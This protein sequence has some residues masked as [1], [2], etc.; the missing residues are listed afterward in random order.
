MSALHTLAASAQI[1]EIILGPAS[2]AR[3]L[4]PTS[5]F[6]AQARQ[7]VGLRALSCQ[8]RRA[9]ASVSSLLQK[10]SSLHDQGAH[11]GVP[12][13]QIF[14]HLYRLPRTGTRLR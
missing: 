1:P 6:P 8:V 10:K 4:F 13:S 14:P 11:D 9:T 7:V 2:L 5:M 3:G 12:P